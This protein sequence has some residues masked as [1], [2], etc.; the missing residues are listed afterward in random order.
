MKNLE[1]F[2]ARKVRVEVKK[3]G[4]YHKGMV[5]SVGKM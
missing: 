4:F 2:E 3:L 1:F 5:S